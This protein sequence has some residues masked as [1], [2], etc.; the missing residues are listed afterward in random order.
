MAWRV[1]KAL[2]AL[3]AEI[4]SG[5]PDRSTKSD[6]AIGDQRH[7]HLRSDHN[8]CDCHD[9]VCARDFTHDPP[10]FDSYVFAEW[11]R[12]RVASGAETRVKYVISD[13]KIFSGEYQQHAPGVWRPYSGTN[14]HSHHVHVSVRHGSDVYDDDTPWGW[15]A[16]RPEEVPL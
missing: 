10:K 11:L 5:A 9:A 4:N 2:E 12:L 14:K 1:A 8:P 13:G 7:A 16:D 15:E 6:G 3:R